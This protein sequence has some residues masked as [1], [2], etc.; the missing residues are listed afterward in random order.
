VALF[1]TLGLP[2]E[3]LG[4]H[5]NEGPPWIL[6]WGGA[7]ITGV[8]LIQLAHL[9]GYRVI[10]A[11]SPKNHEYIRSLGADKVLDR[12][13]CEEKILDGIRLATDDNVRMIPSPGTCW[14]CLTYSYT[15]ED[16]H[17]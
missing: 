1:K 4:S 16:S 3:A 13:A 10:C 11:A 15:G 12:W 8:Y 17:R 9:L 6:I 5:A 2:L 14:R 7:G